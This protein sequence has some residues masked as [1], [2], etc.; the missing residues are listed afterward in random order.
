MKKTII[1]LIIV[2]FFVSWAGPLSFALAA[3]GDANGSVR[4]TAPV[5]AHYCEI[6]KGP[7]KHKNACPL[8]DRHG[9]KANDSGDAHHHG[10][11]RSGDEGPYL[12]A[13]KCH[14]SS[15]TQLTSFYTIDHLFITTLLLPPVKWELE[16]A[17]FSRDELHYRDNIPHPLIKPPRKTS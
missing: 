5:S 4:D 11:E 16:A 3:S 9:K 2:S 12:T 17:F 7:C 15:D 1:T 13:S 10:E 14:L 6:S 8:K